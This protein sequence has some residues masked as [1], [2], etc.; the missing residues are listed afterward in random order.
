M[1]IISL[2]VPACHTKE[3]GRAN[4]LNYGLSQPSKSH[5]LE[6]SKQE[7]K[8]MQSCG[9]ISDEEGIRFSFD[10]FPDRVCARNPHP[11]LCLFGGGHS[12]VC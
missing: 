7:D 8:I 6:M 10:I 2:L 9:R 11:L 3:D 1:C 5:G 4:T 12:G